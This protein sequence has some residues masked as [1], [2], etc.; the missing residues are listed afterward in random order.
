MILPHSRVAG[1]NADALSRLGA[2]VRF[3]CPDEWSGDFEAIPR[4]DDLIEEA[5]VIM[6]LRVQHERHDGKISFT[7]ESIMTIRIN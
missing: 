1:S 3:V 5:D 2:N 7:K 6:L 4:W